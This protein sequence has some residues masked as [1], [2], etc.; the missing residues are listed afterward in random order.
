M[1]QFLTKDIKIEANDE[2]FELITHK[3]RWNISIAHK[4]SKTILFLL[5]RMET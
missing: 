4:I 1:I 5:F 3:E 2:I